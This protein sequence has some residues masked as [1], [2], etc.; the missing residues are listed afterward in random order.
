MQQ[1]GRAILRAALAWLAGCAWVILLHTPASALTAANADDEIVYLDPGGVI[2]VVDPR[3]SS[4]Q[5]AV[6]WVSPEGGWTA[7]AL[8][9][10][11]ADGDMEIVALRPE[12]NGGRLT[13]FDPV[14]TD[15][16][17]GNDKYVAGV[18]WDLLYSQVLA[19]RPGVVVSGDFDP[20]RPGDE[21]LYSEDPPEEPGQNDAPIG[22]TV[23]RN[24]GVAPDGRSWEVMAAATSRF[25]WTWAASGNADG[26]GAD[27]VVL[28]DQDAAN[29]MLF[30]V[31]TSLSVFFRN[32]NGAAP[33]QQ[34][35]LGQFV[36]GGPAELAAVRDVELPGASFWVFRYENN[37][38]V[39]L[40][41]EEFL[42]SPTVIFFADL[43]GTGSEA[44][45]MLRSVRQEV[46]GRARL[47]IRDSANTTTGMREA[48]LDGDNGYQAGAGGDIDGDTRDEIALA[49]DSRIRIYTE[50]E[51]TARFEEILTP[52][53]A[54]TMQLGNVDANGLAGQSRLGA[55]LAQAAATLRVGG[56]SRSVAFQ[57]S[58]IT[59]AE[60][61]AVSVR[62]EKADGWVNVTPLSGQTPLTLTVAFNSDGLNPGVYRDRIVVDAAQSG[63]ADDPLTIP[64]V[65]TVE[66]GI[67]IQPKQLAFVTYPCDAPLTEQGE[68]L[69]IIAPEGA[70]VTF[71]AAVE[72]NPA[73][74]EVAPA[75]GDL[76][77]TLTVTVDA[78][79]PR[80][81]RVDL[82]LTFEGLPGAPDIVE[83]VPVALV[84]AT[85]RLF[86]PTVLAGA[87]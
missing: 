65:L 12:E 64:V 62:L 40:R 5:L 37:T 26:E 78:S 14:A 35:A 68:S 56:D 27:E 38:M 7:I 22:V 50:P 63:V 48:L 77:K 23:L 46:R 21:I 73:W 67:T 28:V 51:A 55:S 85:D 20:V 58:D 52:T 13:V 47:I 36:A 34:A 17:A 43:A 66:S 33:W 76:P 53:D 81:A 49:R 11:N 86:L 70:S 9:D 2:R 1:R 60:R 25:N 44:A 41:S 75:T 82:L 18:A 84:C 39:D 32:Q 69:R 16:P 29:L 19:G 59:N 8:G 87:R 24:A 6:Q 45:V 30:R 61:L 10:F 80:E 72:G 4:T 83:R 74:I 57:V 54:R 3:P 15:A 71:T 31:T 79:R 42:P